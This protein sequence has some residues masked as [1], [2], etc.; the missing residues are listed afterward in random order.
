MMLSYL[1]LTTHIWQTYYELKPLNELYT[2][3]QEMLVEHRQLEVEVQEIAVRP[4]HALL[5]PLPDTL[6]KFLSLSFF[7][8]STD[9]SKLSV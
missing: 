9:G 4:V 7:H 5:K 6:E 8:L 3:W 2:S 1:P